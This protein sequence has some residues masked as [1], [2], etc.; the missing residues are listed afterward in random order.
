MNATLRIS[1]SVNIGT[2]IQGTIIF[3][4][5]KLFAILFTTR[6]LHTIYQAKRQNISH[7]TRNVI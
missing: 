7:R 4:G 5:S 3:K 1:F 2:Y 6:V